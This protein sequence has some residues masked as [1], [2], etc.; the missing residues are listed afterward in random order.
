MAGPA[1]LDRLTIQ[2]GTL[3]RSRLQIENFKF[4]RDRLVTLKDI[5]DEAHP[6]TLVRWWKDRRRDGAQW[7][8]FLVVVSF[9]ILFGLIQSI[10]GV[11]QVYASFKS[12]SDAE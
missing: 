1:Q 4:W 10:E 8:T 6:N 11:L 3:R 9:T 2:C 12:I 5:F 7:Y